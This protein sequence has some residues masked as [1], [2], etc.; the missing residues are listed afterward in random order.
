MNEPAKTEPKGALLDTMYRPVWETDK[1]Q[2]DLFYAKPIL[3]DEAGNELVGVA[4]LI[5]QATVDATMQRQVQY[6]K[7]AFEALHMR[8]ERGERFRLLVRI[9]SVALAT[10]EAAKEVT[11][12]MRTLSVEER[13]HIIPEIT[14]F[15]KSLSLNTLDDITIPLMAFFDTWLAQPEKEQADFTPFSNLNYAGVVLDLL[16]KPIDLKLAGKVFQLFAQRASH[17]RLP[18]W[19][20]G[21]PTPE[22]AKVARICGINVLSGAYMNMDSMLPGP[23]IEG[24]QD[25]MV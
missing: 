22:L 10:S 3:R 9:N 4:P 8:F 12:V 20:L 15:P 2:V 21:I 23:V 6:L 5:R 11:D 13:R 25:F 1:P 17:R 18:T 16:D 24:T 7:Q 19:V 14:A